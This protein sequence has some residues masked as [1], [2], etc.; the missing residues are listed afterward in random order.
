MAERLKTRV[1][2]FNPRSIEDILKR[3][4]DLGQILGRQSKADTLI[5]RLRDK[6]KS[7]KP[8]EGK[9]TVVYEI[10]AR[11][12]R[13]A[14]EDSIVNSIIE[15]AGGVNL[16]KVKKKHVLISPEKVITLAPDFYIYQ[17]GPMNKNPLEP[18]RRS[19]FGLLKSRVVRVDEYEFARP[20]INA[21]QAVV[22]L[23]RIFLEVLK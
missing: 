20:G 7:I 9:P 23:N 11:P 16:I 6:L 12:L 5:R 8:L 1:F 13:V 18:E 10:S 21:F 22:D 17:V 15:H 3:I 2:Y 4:E 14:G 19:Y